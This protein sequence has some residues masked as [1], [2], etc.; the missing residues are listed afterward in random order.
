M[1]AD[2]PKGYELTAE[3]L[4]EFTGAE[5]TPYLEM[6]QATEPGKTYL[7]FSSYQNL[8]NH[9]LWQLSSRTG[10]RIENIYHDQI[11]GVRG[12]FIATGVVIDIAS[13]E[14]PRLCSECRGKFHKGKLSKFEQFCS[15]C[16]R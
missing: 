15:H 8:N 16:L 3:W 6:L 5:R 10:L 12:N 11:A 7:E 13:D 4:L 1:P 14:T 9:L 2:D